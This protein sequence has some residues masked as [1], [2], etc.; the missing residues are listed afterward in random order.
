VYLTAGLTDAVA[1]T[2]AARKLRVHALARPAQ[3]ILV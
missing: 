1:R 3:M 2:F